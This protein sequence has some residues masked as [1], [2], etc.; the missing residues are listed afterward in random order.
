MQWGSRNP[1][2]F[3]LLP[4][5]ASVVHN[6][7]ESLPPSWTAMTR[8]LRRSTS[9]TARSSATRNQQLERMRYEA[10]LAEKQYRLVNPE[11]RLVAAELERRWEQALQAVRQEE[12]KAKAAGAT[13]EPLAAELRRQW[14]EVRPSL[15]RMW[16]S[17]KLSNVRRRSCSGS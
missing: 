4:I 13:T 7:W 11:N 6:F 9:S 17:E 8:R 5:D 16:D 12:E 1:G 10:R 14:D 3:S 2:I 15:R